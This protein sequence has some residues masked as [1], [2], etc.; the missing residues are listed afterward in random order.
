MYT[1]RDGEPFGV[2][3]ELA[4]VEAVTA[5]D[6]RRVART[7]L[8]P[9]NRTVVVARPPGAAGGPGGRP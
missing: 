5:E 2:N 4:R 7:Y 9:D 1:L 6:V 8:V 3:D